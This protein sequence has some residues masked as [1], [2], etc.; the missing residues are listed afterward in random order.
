MWLNILIKFKKEILIFVCLF[1]AL[2][3]G[4]F[5]GQESVEPKVIIETK[6]VEKIKEKIIT[7]EIEKKETKTEKITTITE[8][9]DGTKETKI[10]EKSKSTTDTNSKSDKNSTKNKTT[11]SKP[12]VIYTKNDYRVGVHAGSV[13]SKTIDTGNLKYSMSASVR[14]LGDIWLETYYQHPDKDISLGIAVEF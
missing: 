9:P 14:V 4:Y 13:I 7:V 11:T 8:K 12:K 5:W 10:T 2:T 3:G 1:G 6:I